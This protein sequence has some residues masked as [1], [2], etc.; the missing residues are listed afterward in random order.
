MGKVSVSGDDNLVV[1]EAKDSTIII[2]KYDSG[3]QSE[4]VNKTLY[5]ALI[6]ECDVRN[7]YFVNIISRGGISWY[8]NEEVVQFFFSSMM[9][10]EAL[11]KE[12]RFYIADELFSEL[13]KHC[14]L[15]KELKDSFE[16][17][18]MTIYSAD[19]D[20]ITP[21]C[22]ITYDREIDCTPGFVKAAMEE[23]N[24]LDPHYAFLDY[25]ESFARHD[26]STKNLIKL[27][28]G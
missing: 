2:N 25:A 11:V 12:K 14:K 4:P 20:A 28:K 21:A 9:K 18:V 26:V 6:E 7:Y 13:M 3:V 1:N 23:F 8:T 27:I 10:L 15:T 16:L 5:D 22:D 19:Q 17:L 24:S